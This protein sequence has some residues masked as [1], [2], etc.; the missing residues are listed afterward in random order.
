MKAMKVINRT[1]RE[2]ELQETMREAALDFLRMLPVNGVEAVKHMETL[3]LCHMEQTLLQRAEMYP[4]DTSLQH[5]YTER[6]E[7]RMMTTS[8]EAFLHYKM[9]G[10]TIGDR[11]TFL[12]EWLGKSTMGLYILERA[13]LQSV[14]A[15]N[16]MVSMPGESISRPRHLVVETE[17]YQTLWEKEKE[18]ALAFCQP[19]ASEVPTPESLV[20]GS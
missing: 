16:L 3:I 15:E 14:G 13:L 8:R 5:I 18:T 6:S 17:K 9:E 10:V 1:E 19:P 20:G 12:T 2:K 7:L 11:I 4:K